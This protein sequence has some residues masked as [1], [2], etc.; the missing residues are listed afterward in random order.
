MQTG[1]IMMMNGYI[2]NLKTTISH[3][4]AKKYEIGRLE[5]KQMGN[6][7][8]E[9]DKNLRY[10]HLASLAK[11]R[12]KMGCDVI[13]DGTFGKKAYRQA[14][15]DIGE[16]LGIEDIVIVNCC[17]KNE[18]EIWRRINERQKNDSLCISEWQK[19]NH[20]GLDS[21]LYK[22]K[23][24]SI[25]QIDTANYTVNAKNSR[26]RFCSDLT[27]KLSEAM[28]LIKKQGEKEQPSCSTMEG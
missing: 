27:N 19:K 14:I 22:G 1:N 11:E 16:E 23:P 10:K 13:L 21:D 26:T 28:K 24:P 20:E 7:H 9:K 3:S 4:L 8:R 12:A 15:Y 17:C 18:Q 6:I 5:T 2:C 25:I